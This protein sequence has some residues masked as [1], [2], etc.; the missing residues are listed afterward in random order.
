MQKKVK[1]F[2][3]AFVAALLFLSC[4]QLANDA[5]GGAIPLSSSKS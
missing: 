4:S 1:W 2:I 3:V 5:G